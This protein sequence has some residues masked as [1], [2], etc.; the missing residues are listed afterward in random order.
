MRTV[1]ATTVGITNCCAPLENDICNSIHAECTKH[2]DLKCVLEAY[3]FILGISNGTE[4]LF[5]AVLAHFQL[6]S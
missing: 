4:V 1:S 6:S 5:G 3:F 2:E